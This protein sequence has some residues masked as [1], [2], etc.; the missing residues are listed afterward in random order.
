MAL[1]NFQGAGRPLDLNLPTR[2]AT[3]MISLVFWAAFAHKT[4][5]S[6]IS[7]TCI[8]LTRFESH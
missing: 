2:L 8:I 5:E 6:C 4:C 7:L 3:Q 1:W